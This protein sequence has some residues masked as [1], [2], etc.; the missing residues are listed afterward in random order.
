MQNVLDTML[1]TLVTLIVTAVS[2]L[3]IITMIKIW[4]M[5][6]DVSEIN[7]NIKKLLED[8]QENI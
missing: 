8:K 5:T 6:N 1:H 7:R 2:I 4:R 3:N